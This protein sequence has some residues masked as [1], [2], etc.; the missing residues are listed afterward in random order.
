MWI[1]KP[2]CLDLSYLNM[3]GNIFWYR[4]TTGLDIVIT[5]NFVKQS[6]AAAG[7][8]LPYLNKAVGSVRSNRTESTQSYDVCILLVVK[9]GLRRWYVTATSAMAFVVTSLTALLS[10]P[11]Y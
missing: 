11:M 6:Q 4:Y 9:D 7:V 1:I 2:L 8:I 5:M 10:I 3:L